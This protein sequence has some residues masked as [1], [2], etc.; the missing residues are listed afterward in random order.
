M[1]YF[2]LQIHSQFPLSFEFNQFFLKFLAYHHVSNRFRTFM[3]DSESRRMEAGWMLEESK[4]ASRPE[5]MVGEPDASHVS[6]SAACGLSIWEYIDEYHKHSPTFYN[7]FYTTQNQEPV[8]IFSLSSR[9]SAYVL[10]DS[11]KQ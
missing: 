10:H 3:L 1:F 2:S 5:S 9:I 7:F 4:M 8:C 6:A 11:Q